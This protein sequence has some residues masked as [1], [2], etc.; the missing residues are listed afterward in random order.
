MPI[1]Y[2]LSGD[3]STVMMVRDDETLDDLIKDGLRVI[4]GC[5]GYRF[6]IDSV[7]LAGFATLLPGNLVCDL[8]TGSGVISILLAQRDSTCR[9]KALEI[10]ESLSERA[11]RSIKINHLE[12]R[13]EV[14]R[15]DIREIK[16]Y[17]DPACFDLVVANPPFWEAGKGRLPSHP[18][19]ALARHELAVTLAEVI[20][21]AAYVLKPGG[22]LA[23]VHRASRLDEIIQLTGNCHIPAKRVRTVHPRRDH[24]ANLLLVEGIKGASPGVEIL[25][26]LVIYEDDGSY[27][28][29]IRYLYYGKED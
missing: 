29:E 28:R 11:T 23:L 18:E 6:S 1:L 15:G 16:R 2:Q 27:T 5:N 7:L 8:G 13:I 3:K 10:Q 24:S 17:F 19:V 14:I 12:D 26:P 22:R 9:I 4:Q 20:A 25:P 21:G